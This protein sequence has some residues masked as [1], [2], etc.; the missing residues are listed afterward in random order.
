VG[1]LVRKYYEWYG[2][3]FQTYVEKD[4]RDLLQI[5]NLATFDRFVRVSASRVGQLVNFS[6]MAGEVGLSQPTMA[7]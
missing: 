3:Y 6:S 2:D 4:I 5:E 7:R 1:I